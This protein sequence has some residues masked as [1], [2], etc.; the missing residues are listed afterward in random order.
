M[1][2]RLSL[3]ALFSIVFLFSGHT[4]DVEVGVYGGGSYYL[5]D[6]NPSMHFQGTQIAY[7]VLARYNIDT[8]W[9]VKFSAYRGKIKGN[10]G[11]SWFLPNRNLQFSS[12]IT[13]ISAVAEFNFLPYFTGSKRNFITPYVYA[14][15][16]LFF[17]KPSSDGTDLQPLGTEGQQIGY[18]GR[19]PYSQVSFNI[20]FGLGVKFSVSRKIGITAFWE[21]HKTFSDYL[22][23]VSKTYY[24]DGVAIDP[25]DVEQYLSDPALDHQPGMQRGNSRNQDWYSFSGVTITYK[26][27]LD[28]GKKCRDVYK[29]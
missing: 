11:D 28:G 24:L 23:D 6:L 5:G 9:A 18:E 10:S 13:D 4:Q 26:F 29:Y 1:G 2:M 12:P 7:G 21:M 27:A 25:N 15:I 14:G 19:K 3:I 16:G 22:D 8:R 20:P 17:F